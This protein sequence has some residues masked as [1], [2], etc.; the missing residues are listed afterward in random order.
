M[1]N[2]RLFGSVQQACRTKPGFSLVFERLE[3][4]H[5]LA[6][7]L[8]ISEIMA[9]NDHSIRD[10]DDQT[11]DWIELHNAGDQSANLD[12]WFL[13][14]DAR[15][16]TK[17]PFPDGFSIAPEEYQLVY[18][19]GRNRVMPNQE[20][21]TNFRLSSGGEF[22]ALVAPD[23]EG[24]LSIVSSFDPRFPALSDD[25]S[26]GLGS[27]EI[28]QSLV[29][30]SSVTRLHIPAD[31][32]LGTD[33]TRPDFNDEA[34]TDLALPAGFAVEQEGVPT[35]GFTVQM[36]DV[37][38]G[39]VGRFES[40]RTVEAIFAGDFAESDFNVTRNVK[41]V[42][43][44]VDFGGFRGIKSE[45][46]PYL[47]GTMDTS[48]SDFALRATA[49]IIIPPGEWTVAFGSNDGG[50]LRIPGVEFLETFN[51]KGTPDDLT[52]GDGQIWFDGLRGYGFTRATFTIGPDPLATSVDTMFYNRD[53]SD[54]F[55]LLIRPGH[56]SDRPRNSKSKEWTLLADG[57]LDWSVS[58]L[59]TVAAPE[60]GASLRGSV[61]PADLTNHSVYLRMPF[62]WSADTV[63][64]ELALDVRIN[65]GFVAY[66]NGTEI[67][68]Y[69]MPD[70]AV[71]NSEAVSI[72]EDAAT[73]SP[74]RFA[75]VDEVQLL[76][77]GQNVLAIQAATNHGGD[78][79][80]FVLPTLSGVV[81]SEIGHQFLQYATPGA[82][83]GLGAESI[84]DEVTYSLSSQMFAEP[85]ALTLSHTDETARIHYTTDGS[86]PT[87]SSLI[88]VGPMTVD[89]TTQ[90]RSRA[91]A[92]D[93]VA[94]PV[95]SETY[96]LIGDD[97][98]EFSSDMPIL[99]L[100]NFDQ[101]PPERTYQNAFVTLHELGEDG[102]SR[103]LETPSVTR[104]IGMRLRGASTS[105]VEKTNYRIEFRDEFGDDQNVRWLDLPSESDFSLWSPWIWDRTMVR[106][107]FMF[108]LGRQLG[109][110]Q[111]RTRF[112]EV[113][114]D[115]D[116]DGLSMSDYMGIY[117]VMETIKVDD[118]RLDI[119]SL[120]R[121]DV[122][123]PEVTGG[124]IIE[125]GRG[126]DRDS[127]K[128]AIGYPPGQRYVY[129]DP[130][131]EDLAP[132]QQAYI[133][134]VVDEFESALFGVDFNDPENGYGPHI[135]LD[136]FLDH[137]WMRLLSND[138]DGLLVSTYW[139]VDREGPI[140]MGPLWDFDRT[141]GNDSDG[142]SA[143]PE[144]FSNQSVNYLTY[145]WWGRLFSDPNFRQAWIDRYQNLRAD[146]YFDMANFSDLIDQLSTLPTAEVRER[147]YD[148]WRVMTPNGGPFAE[149]GQTGYEGEVSHL[150]GWL[151]LRLAWFD[152]QFTSPPEIEF[153]P[154]DAE[155]SMVLLKFNADEVYYTVDGSDPR[156]SGGTISPTATQ[157]GLPF[158]VTEG[159]T[160]RARSFDN[161]RRLPTNAEI[162][163]SGIVESTVD[164]AVPSVVSVQRGDGSGRLDQLDSVS[165]QFSEDVG[166]S[167]QA[168][169]LQI[170]N[171]TTGESISSELVS[172]TYDEATRVARWEISAETLD[173]GDYEF[174]LTSDDIRDS[175]GNSLDGDGD[176]IPGDDFTVNFVH[177]VAGDANQDF[178]FNSEDLVAVFIVGE[179]EDRLVNNST[180]SDGDWNGDG[181]FTSDDLVAAFVAG[182]FVTE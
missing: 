158:A 164:F 141:M 113:F 87:E 31:D 171:I 174:R 79:A 181:E 50:Y 175:S 97:A 88:Y 100:E 123:A 90:V 23:G 22:L 114:A 180:W 74:L 41:Q 67:A 146:G 112:V 38:G 61:S 62:E 35:P 126:D 167:L 40:A 106:N 148:R 155:L 103:L 127:F 136:S 138:P 54:S 172:V 115:T 119:A 156:A 165:I 45:T 161:R 111:P 178:V 48:L 160:I 46:Q 142:R 15:N 56:V 89:A 95:T 125:N 12:G 36:I 154:A 68:R 25:V 37:D 16:L 60:F 163:W 96:V 177:T 66:L 182:A 137:H 4:R 121:S 75:L 7:E 34:W 76:R 32:A 30:D 63:F 144:S 21:H 122:N 153:F 162:P 118:D 150:K 149:P 2:R 101:G 86:M 94:S 104:M 14:D 173:L 70:D 33:W 1:A 147:T 128:S 42:F 107:S 84:L 18:A 157:Y 145:G 159:T 57:A 168:S 82:S 132:Q 17:W 29:S 59:A 19:S 52:P 152:A 110:Y 85:F 143:S 176:G 102:R 26:Y 105:A 131:L 77:P 130:G 134:Q 117:V 73:L 169:D 124:Y 140:T 129:D 133:G 24:N 99:V 10:F 69:N 109:Y 6:A 5:V 108:E 47:D 49:E 93:R 116:G 9:A 83:N 72:R 65:D 55:E 91:F 81:K 92:K 8:V 139:H 151:Q 3:S 120:R 44:R 28:P 71:W 53:G 58:T 51:E 64:D 170:Q 166:A 43:P 39:N 11:S 80:F 13:T 135:E 179:Y 78:H 27:R 98:R 20:I